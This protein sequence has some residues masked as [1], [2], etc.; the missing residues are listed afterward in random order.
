MTVSSCMLCFEGER[1]YISNGLAM[2]FIYIDALH[3]ANRSNSS[4]TASSDNRWIETFVNIT[5]TAMKLSNTIVEILRACNLKL[6][7]GG[8]YRKER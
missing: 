4:T 7:L 8:K 3:N 2:A 1:R 6:L 5:S